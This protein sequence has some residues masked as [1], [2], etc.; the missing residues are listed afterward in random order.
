MSV[1]A[2]STS[3]ISDG[4]IISVD[5]ASIQYDL[6]NEV[7]V[8]LVGGGGSGGFG[9][10]GGG[11]GGAVLYNPKVI[12]SPGGSYSITIG[13][14][15]TGHTSNASNNNGQPT[16]AF[17]VTAL[18]GGAG[19]NENGDDTSGRSSQGSQGGNNGGSSYNAGAATTTL[20]NQPVFNS[21]VQSPGWRI[22]AGYTGGGGNPNTNFYYGCGGGGG[23][24]GVGESVL[25]DA[26]GGGRGGPGAPNDILGTMY[27]WGAG[28][29]GASYGS[30]LYRGGDGGLGGGG[31]AG[32]DGG[33]GSGS[34][35]GRG[36][37]RGYN[38][39]GSGGTG[40]NLAGG[41]GGTNTGSGGGSGSN[42]NG[43]GGAGAAGITIIKY[44][45]PQKAT[46]GN[47]ITSNN[48]YT[49]HIFTSNGTFAPLSSNA[50]TNG[51]TV[52]GLRDLSGNGNHMYSSGN[53]TYSTDG[54]GSVVLNGSTQLLIGPGNAITNLPAYS[55]VTVDVW[56]K[57]TTMPSPS[58]WVKVW[59]K[60]STSNGGNRT[61]G[62]WYNP[63]YNTTGA[64]LYQ[65]NYN[66]FST[67]AP[68]TGVWWNLVGVSNRNY[69]SIYVNGVLETTVQY[70][71]DNPVNTDTF[72]A[73]YGYA[74][75]Y[76][77]GLISSARTYNRALSNA[78]ILQNYN[79][80]RS[81]YG[82]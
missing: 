21:T 32:S 10:G 12:V 4:L 8:L 15:G 66:C 13:I 11:G 82:R 38:N 35:A 70:D 25:R 17:G 45:G 41:A 62:L 78:E 27:Y 33:T 57:I 5:A 65:R 60:Q 52:Y 2:G 44:A 40:T 51:A 56:F 31:G 24:G 71:G 54:G 64:F 20:Y 79:Q 9:H 75:T 74:H 37:L 43:V 61:W 7:Q 28:G 39:G 63:T 68:T 81:R 30:M 76:H 67:T 48:G 3:L 29:G 42:E 49:I 58:D 23:A 59:G 50:S 53:P 77:N 73:G 6:L 1:A 16:Q 34:Y 55:D 36:G 80:M 14:G 47:I 19:G 18:G 69:H 72:T 22:S 46:G 26:Y